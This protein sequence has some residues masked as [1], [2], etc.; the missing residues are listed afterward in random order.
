MNSERVPA[1]NGFPDILQG[2]IIAVMASCFVLDVGTQS[3]AGSK[4]DNRFKQ[5]QSAC[6]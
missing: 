6:N 3:Q 5:K 2:A 4:C 1:A